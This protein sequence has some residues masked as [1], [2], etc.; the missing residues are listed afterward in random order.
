MIDIY[1][2]YMN[3]V[4]NFFNQTCSAGYGHA[5]EIILQKECVC[6]CAFLPATYLPIYL[7]MLICT[8]VSK[9][10]SSKSNLYAKVKAK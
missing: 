4:L 9:I 7:S 5:T 6:V 10:L 8:H 1:Y 3:S 2:F